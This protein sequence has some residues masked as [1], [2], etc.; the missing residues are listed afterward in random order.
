MPDE[1]EKVKSRVYCGFYFN[2]P[3]DKALMADF[4]TWRNREGK[5]K[6]DA[7]KVMMTEFLKRHLKGNSQLSLHPWQTGEELSESAQEALSK[8]SEV[9][10][11][12][13]AWNKMTLE[14]LRVEAKKRFLDNFDKNAIRF[15]IARKEKETQ[16]IITQAETSL[17]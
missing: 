14:E 2:L 8:K 9:D 3:Q 6:T 10:R 7:I 16:A 13:P 15:F 1:D 12:I 17:T 4:K 11:T 5:D